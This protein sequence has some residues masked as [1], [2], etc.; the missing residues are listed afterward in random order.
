MYLC[1]FYVAIP[2]PKPLYTYYGDLFIAFKS[3][4]SSYPNL[5]STENRQLFLF[6]KNQ[7]RQVKHLLTVRQAESFCGAPDDVTA[8]YPPPAGL[9]T[10]LV[11][12]QYF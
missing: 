2:N 9:P 4:T 6:R 7:K 11:D 10:L 8:I 1:V 12:K 5:K 3:W